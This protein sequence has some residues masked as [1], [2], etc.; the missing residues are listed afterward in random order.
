MG[1][2]CTEEGVDVCATKK[3]L[4]GQDAQNYSTLLTLG[5][6]GNPA[7]LYVIVKTKKA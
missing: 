4:Y 5:G 7:P 2:S 6:A 1:I 3:P